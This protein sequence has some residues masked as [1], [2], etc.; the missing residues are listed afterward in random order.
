MNGCDIKVFAK[1]RC[2]YCYRKEILYPKQKLKEKKHYKITPVSEKR[3][4]LNN[5]YER[6]KKEKWLDLVFNKKNKCFFTDK[7]ID[8]VGPVPHFHH[9]LGRDGELLADMNYAFPCY[10]KPHREYHDLRYEYKDLEKIEWYF[11]WLQ[12]MKTELPIIYHKEMRLIERANA[13]TKK[14]TTTNTGN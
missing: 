12:R 8:P 2:I 13:T 5:E 3:K 4:L 11:S 6:K 7:I 10:F 9:T 1:D 14:K